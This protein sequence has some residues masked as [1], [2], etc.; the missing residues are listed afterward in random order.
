MAANY[1]KLGDYKACCQQCGEDFF[2]SVMLLQWDGWRVCKRCF[3]PRH[4]QEVIRPPRPS[5]PVPW[6]SECAG[7]GGCEATSGSTCGRNLNTMVE[8]GCTTLG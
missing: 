6:V 3:D 8:N 4:P 7:E 1:F 2:A 5:R